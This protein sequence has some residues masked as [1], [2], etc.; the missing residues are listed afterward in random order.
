MFNVDAIIQQLNLS[1]HPEGGYF[2]E[3]YR[4]DETIAA[5]HLPNR[6]NGDR[7]FSTAIY[8]L[9]KGDQFSA[10][11]RLKS[12][13]GWH[14]YRGSS[15]TIYCIAPDGSRTDITLGN[16]IENGE[17]PQAVIKKGTW[18]AAAVNDTSPYTL[19]GCTVVPGFDFSDFEMGEREELIKEFPQHA[20]LIG[21]L[22]GEG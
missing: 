9:L 16:D 17:T 19:V 1:P 15:L 3:T 18:F 7:A 14:F 8:F 21:K 22:T 11:H 2:R 13:E 12:D 6:Y 20:K 10:F 5:G 4:S